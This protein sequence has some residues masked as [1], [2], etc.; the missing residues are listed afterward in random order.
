MFCLQSPVPPRKVGAWGPQGPHR[1][2]GDPSM[3]PPRLTGTPSSSTQG[4]WGPPRT[5]KEHGQPPGTSQDTGRPPQALHRLHRDPTNHMGT[6]PRFPQG[7][8]GPRRHTGT[9]PKLSTGYTGTPQT[10]RGSPQSPHKA[11]GDLQ[12]PHR[13]HEDPLKVLTRHT[14]TPP[15]HLR[16]LPKL[17]TRHAGIP[18][19][20]HV[21]THGTPPPPRWTRCCRGVAEGGPPQSPRAQPGGAPQCPPQRGARCRVM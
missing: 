21:H 3:V 16:I 4:T 9:P 11:H 14:G 5:H 7:T 8:R 18:P 20:A 10:T 17:P 13:V 19:Q 15:R 12:G 1:A 2:Q 6:P